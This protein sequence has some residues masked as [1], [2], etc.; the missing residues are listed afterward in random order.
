M[1]TKRSTTRKGNGSGKGG[2][3]EN[4]ILRHVLEL[5][6]SMNSRIHKHMLKL[7]EEVWNL[8]ESD[9][10]SM[11]SEAVRSRTQPK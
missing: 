8:K 11:H 2:Y 7:A 6:E 4:Q 10:F 3:S 1:A 5:G 9:E